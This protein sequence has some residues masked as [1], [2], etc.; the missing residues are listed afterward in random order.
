MIVN[1]SIP[2][3]QK[4]ILSERD[5]FVFRVAL[6]VAW[7]SDV[8]CKGQKIRI[9]LRGWA[10]DSLQFPCRARLPPPSLR[11][12]S[13][14]QHLWHLIMESISSLFEPEK[15]I[16][17]KIKQVS[18]IKIWRLDKIDKLRV[19]AVVENILLSLSPRLLQCF[20][21]DAMYLRMFYPSN[22]TTA[23]WKF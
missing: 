14:A 2:L 3:I 19:V 6:A 17:P 21:H 4:K 22:I 8:F 5:V 11:P 7:P 12:P 9:S 18:V 20:H 15:I 13:P 1:I 23:L 16:I 10:R